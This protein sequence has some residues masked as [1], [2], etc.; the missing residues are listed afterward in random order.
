[1]FTVT[2]EL[3]T[4]R[5]VATSFDDRSAGEW[6][7]HPAR[8]FSAAVA[9]WADHGDMDDAE[10]DALEW[11]ETLAPPTITCSIGA[12]EV[13]AREVVTHFVPVNDTSVVAR[14][15]ARSYEQLVDSERAFE[16]ADSDDKARAKAS[17]RLAKAEAKADVDSVKVTAS[18]EAPADRV[19]ILG[20]QRNKQPRTFPTILPADPV[21]SYHWTPGA[22]SS[23]DE[24]SNRLRVLDGLL[25]RIARVGH[26]STPVSVELDA[27]PHVDSVDITLEPGDAEATVG[28]RVP[29]AGQLRGL[30]RAYEAS[31]QATETRRMP[32]RLVAYRRPG[33]RVDPVA[34]NIG[35]RWLLLEPTE[36]S[37]LMARDIPGVAKLLRSALMSICGE[38][39][40]EI[41]EF[42]SGHRPRQA[43]ESGP[44]RPSRSPHLMV[45]GLP[46]SGHRHAT[47]EVLGIALVLPDSG[48]GR[49][50][51]A[52]NWALLE[53]LVHR[54]LGE[55]EG[56]L[57]LRGKRQ[58]I[59]LRA[60]RLAQLTNSADVA[61]WSR[62]SSRWASVTPV[63]LPRNPG[64][65][66]HADRA[67]RAVATANA[68]SAI[69]M[70]CE[71]IGLPR[72]ID[73][74]IMLDAPMRGTRPVHAFPP[75]K[76]G[77]LTRVQ[78]HARLTF[79]EPVAGPVVLGAGRYNGLGLFT[80]TD[81][82]VNESLEV[83]A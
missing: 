45:L 64:N 54:F 79:A 6:P 7:P 12:D 77:K 34:S 1:M 69:A 11:W 27:D 61:N 71:Y 59:D 22:E 14:D 75:A 46:F 52:T 66:G 58:P 40:A 17:K 67:K 21:V 4:G 30:V 13:G 8:V 80:P 78:V 56:R 73:V 74:E 70:S 18:G 39:G 42:I 83:G 37:R 25:S 82:W 62:P 51:D 23:E 16:E 76:T 53:Q 63:A 2:V 50:A 38:N 72:P 43:G 9:A 5:Y 81:P 57:R 24:V 19:G 44:T 68:E 60:A 15:T 36:S 28:L 47:G 33:T 65:L 35:R 41:P 29:V 32:A 3:L 26:S 49:D 48:R 31:A 10:R 20:P 55:R